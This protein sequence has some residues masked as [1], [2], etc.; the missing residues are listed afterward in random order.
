MSSRLPRPRGDRPDTTAAGRSR[1]W[2]PPPTRGSS[3]LD[4]D[5]VRREVGSPAHAGIVPVESARTDTIVRLPRPRGDRPQV[6]THETVWSGAPPPTRGSSLRWRLDDAFQSGSPAHAGIVPSLSRPI[7]PMTRLPRPRGDRPALGRLFRR[8]SRAPPPTRGSSRHGIGLRALLSGSP[9]HA[10]IV[11]RH[12]VCRA[13]KS[14]LPRPRGDRPT[15]IS[16][17]TIAPWAPPPTR[18]S[19]LRRA[20]PV[21]PHRGSPA[22]AGIVP[23]C[24][25]EP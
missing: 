2:A 20:H 11:P 16:G 4:V 17:E 12:T 8:R 25:R 10:G 22:H 6:R 5:P 13:S 19:S 7:D 9:A 15:G 1:R 21:E 14:G 23:D 18:G 3:R 24:P